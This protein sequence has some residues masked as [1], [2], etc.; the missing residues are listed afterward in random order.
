VTQVPL[1]RPPR[2]TR[3]PRSLNVVRQPEAKAFAAE[4]DWSA[5]Y[6]TDEEDMGEGCEQGV[7]IRLLFAVL[8]ELCRL[9][10]LADA[11]VGADNFF[12][13]VPNE[14]LVRVSPDVYLLRGVQVTKPLPSVWETWR[15]GHRPPVIAFEIVS[16]DWK[17]DYQ[18][19]P[20]KYA[21]LGV[22]ELCIFDPEAAASRA[23]RGRVALQVYRRAPDGAFVCAYEGAG[24]TGSEVL[25]ATLVVVEDGPSRRL[26][27]A[28]DPEGRRLIPTADEARRAAE[29]G[30]EVERAAREVERAAREVERAAREAAE[31][32]IGALR[33]RL[34]ALGERLDPPA[35]A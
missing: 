19:N 21:Q 34:A 10:G 5:W 8:E 26:R 27:L 12:G 30:R 2:P 13:W 22:Q 14:P 9:R 33:A 7:I 4:V 31:R 25:D 16:K 23:A 17:K 11:F 6:L 28:E 29:Q 24:P 20:E 1:S 15:D 32:E 18:L 3:P 35:S